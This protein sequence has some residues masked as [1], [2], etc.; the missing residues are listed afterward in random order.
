MHNGRVTVA[1][2]R[3]GGASIQVSIP[4]IPADAGT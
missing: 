3:G 1:D 2:A 4:T